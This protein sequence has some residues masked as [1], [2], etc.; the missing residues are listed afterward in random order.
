MREFPFE[1]A[2]CAALEADSDGVVARQLG[3]HTR[4]VDVVEVLPG[5]ELDRR[6]EITPHAIPGPAIESEVGVGTARRPR[7]AFDVRRDRAA[8]IADRAVEIGFFEAERRNGNRHVRKAV[9]Y[10]D[11]FRGLRAIENKPDLDRPGDLELQLRKDVSLGLFDE[12][13]LATASYVT[14][15]HLNRIPDS[16]GVWRFDPDSGT[17]DVVRE[18]T[19]LSPD[20]TGI[21]V[22][23]QSPTRVDIEPVT[24]DR[25]ARLR[26]RLAER[27]YGK[28]WRPPSL[29]GCAEATPRGPEF[30][31]DD[32]LPYCEWKGRFVD[33]A[34]ECGPDCAGYDP[35]DPP[36]IDTDAI[37]DERS[38]WTV[39]PEGV[40]RQQVGLDRFREE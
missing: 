17:I 18:A 30:G 38:A 32:V 34:R 24:A 15:A 33:P 28:G 21:A 7:E 13:V 39:D 6:T 8:S 2:V 29:P 3:T 23:E 20:D 1:L 4:I 22:L 11:W 35:T 31:T 40:A 37:R 25:K 10:P 9:E 12:V 16:V 14:G 27:A 19:A 5:P 26:R 36:E